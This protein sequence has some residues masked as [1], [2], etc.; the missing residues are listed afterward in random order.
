MKSAILALLGLAL[1]TVQAQLVAQPGAIE[2]SLNAT[3]INNV[4]QTFVP[5][6]AYYALNNHTFNVN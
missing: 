5:I 6:M 4:M 2:L 1:M 3:S